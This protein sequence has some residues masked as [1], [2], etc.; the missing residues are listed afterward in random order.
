[1]GVF[2]SLE[3]REAVGILSIAQDA[4]ANYRGEAVTERRRAG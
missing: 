4:A 1:M 2:V 3:H